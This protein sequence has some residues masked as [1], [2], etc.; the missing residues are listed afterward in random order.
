M[1]GGC[2]MLVRKI[3]NIAM[4]QDGAIWGNYLFRFKENGVGTVYSIPE[5]TQISC[6]TLDQAD[7]IA[8][9]SNAVVFGNEFYDPADEFPL[10][11]CNIYNNYAKTENPLKGVCCVYRLQHNGDTFTSTLVQL[12]EIGFTEDV[13]YWRSTDGANDVRPYGNFVIDREKGE[14]W[15]FTMRDSD[16]TSR[17]FSFDLPKLSD[18]EMDTDYGVKKVVLKT[19]DIKTQF[20]CPYH[21]YV[22]GACFHNGKIYSLEGFGLG[23][24]NAAAMRII[25][26]VTGQQLHHI[27]FFD[28]GLTNEPELIDF[29]GDTCYYSDAHGNAFILEF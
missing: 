12:I 11:Y 18:G 4:G 10:L 26:T 7:R 17:Y 28:L 25:D 15:A 1:Q 16:N 21:H 14:Y 27:P 3:A 6:F 23:A 2:I 13:R 29:S 8:P 9:H 20:D 5:F 24:K 22:Q 19:T